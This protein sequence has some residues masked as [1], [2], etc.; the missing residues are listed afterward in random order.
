MTEENHF[1]KIAE[2]IQKKQKRKIHI[3]KLLF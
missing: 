1:S 2:K 3:Y